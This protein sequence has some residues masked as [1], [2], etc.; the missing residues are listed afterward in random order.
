VVDEVDIFSFMINKIKLFL[1]HF[2][3]TLKVSK[4]VFFHSRLLTNG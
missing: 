4:M 3:A 1:F 2:E